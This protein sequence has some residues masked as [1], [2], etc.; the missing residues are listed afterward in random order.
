M[1]SITPSSDLRK[2]R[3]G[4][5]LA[6]GGSK[7]AFHV[8]VL[9]YLAEAGLEVD[10][11]SGASIGAFNGS[12][13]AASANMAEAASRLEQVWRFIADNNPIKLGNEG[14]GTADFAWYLGLMVSM[15]Q[16]VILPPLLDAALVALIPASS[17]LL[18]RGGLYS[19]SPVK[20]ALKRVLDM[21]S[22]RK[23]KPF[24]VSVYRSHG[25]AWLDFAVGALGAF[26]ITD[27]PDS[28]FLHVQALPESEQVQAILASAA[29][30][31]FFRAKKVNGQEYVD[32]GTGGARGAKGNTPVA[33]EWMPS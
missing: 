15:G 25:K 21:D 9:R 23:G 1:P 20:D 6:G 28:E 22:L 24:H 5:A 19:D 7:G 30:P 10:A 8:G 27:T 33:R 14:P 3:L 13:V 31:L 12:V 29:I 32:G 18:D 16:T 11:V 26:G 4:I 2:P 17:S